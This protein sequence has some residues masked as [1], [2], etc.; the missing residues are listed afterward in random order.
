MTE[1]STKQVKKYPFLTRTKISLGFIDRLK[2]LCHG[3]LILEV[4]SELENEP[5]TFTKSLDYLY[6]PGFLGK[7]PKLSSIK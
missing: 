7:K 4:Q 2:V 6:I 3:Q 5:G 1:I